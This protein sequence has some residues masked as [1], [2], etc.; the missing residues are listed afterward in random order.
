MHTAL[1]LFPFVYHKDVAGP[2]DT[3]TGGARTISTITQLQFWN[4]NLHQLIAIDG[5]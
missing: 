3:V 5:T 4:D 2:P 1:T